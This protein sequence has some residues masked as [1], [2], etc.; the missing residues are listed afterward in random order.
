MFVLSLSL[1][2][3]QEIAELRKRISDMENEQ[4]RQLA[5]SKRLDEAMTAILEVRKEIATIREKENR[6]WWKRFLGN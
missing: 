5:R 4:A 6:P 2:E 3:K 1:A